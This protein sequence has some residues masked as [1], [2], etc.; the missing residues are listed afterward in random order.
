[1]AQ[2]VEQFVKNVLT[3]LTHWAMCICCTLACLFV[4]A[5]DFSPLKAVVVL[6]SAALADCAE[7][8]AVFL[9]A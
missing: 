6:Q 3:G 4:Y 8:T 1:M 7:C 5:G 9:L 2:L